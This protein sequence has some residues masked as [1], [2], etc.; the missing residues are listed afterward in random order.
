MAVVLLLF[1]ANRYMQHCKCYACCVVVVI[2]VCMDASAI[3]IAFSICWHWPWCW[4]WY[5]LNATVLPPLLKFAQNIQQMLAKLYV[6][7]CVYVF[8]Y[9]PSLNFIYT[10]LLLVAFSI[11]KCHFLMQIVQ[12]MM[13]WR[14]DLNL[15]HI[16]SIIHE[17]QTIIFVLALA[18]VEF[19]AILC[20]IDFGGSCMVH[21]TSFVSF[22]LS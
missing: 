19:E 15:Y 10:L 2:M 7:V 22:G 1:L 18:F 12:N 3:A 13:S 9:I 8:L 4:C 11:T 6:F 5:C 16:I 20:Q 17:T 21:T 14:L